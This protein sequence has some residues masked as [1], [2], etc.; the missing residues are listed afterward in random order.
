[1]EPRFIGRWLCACVAYLAA[2]VSMRAPTTYYWTSYNIDN[3]WSN[4]ANWSTGVAPLNDGSSDIR[5]DSADF[6]SDV[7]LDASQNI[8]SLTVTSLVDNDIDFKATTGVTLTIQNGI[9]FT[10]S[11]TYR[12]LH[13]GKLVGIA[14]PSIQ[15]WEVD[16]IC[17]I[18]PNTLE[19]SGI[20]SGAGGIIKN[21]RRRPD[22][23]QRQHVHGRRD[24]EGWQ[25]DNW[26]QPGARGQHHPRQRHTDPQW[27][28][29]AS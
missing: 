16:S 19:V 26:K 24:S 2:C 8:K 25:T 22:F 23:A 7:L 10:P 20:V 15:T 6:R 21:R 1:M 3:R 29:A 9:T 28:H 18:S 14:L 11:S 27:R 4:N 13:F 5:F 12:W 17:P